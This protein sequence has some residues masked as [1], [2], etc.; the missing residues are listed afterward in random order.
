MAV[1]QGLRRGNS[2]FMV[3]VGK[4]IN[5]DFQEKVP[6]TSECLKQEVAAYLA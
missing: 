4:E 2:Y 1:F 6:T 5:K 3:E